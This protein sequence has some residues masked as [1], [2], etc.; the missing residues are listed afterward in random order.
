MA[1]NGEGP[2]LP[3]PPIAV[4]QDGNLLAYTAAV[5]D[6]PVRLWLRDSESLDPRPV[7]GTEGAELPVF[8]AFPNRF[9]RIVE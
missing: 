7:P 4:S 6:E 5:S 2:W 1:L 3:Y 8:S 9:R